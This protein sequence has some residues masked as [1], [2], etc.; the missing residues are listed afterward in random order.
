MLKFI[1]HFIAT[2]F[3]SGLSPKAPGTVGT[4][5]C[6]VLVWAFW[7]LVP[8][9]DQ[10]IAVFSPQL[11]CLLSSIVGLISIDFYYRDV[12]K[13][14]LKKFDPQEVVIDEFA[15]FL[16]TLSFLPPNSR[17]LL[18]AFVAFRFFDILKP[19]PIKIFEKQSGAWGVMLDDLAAGIY[20][21]ITLSLLLY[22]Y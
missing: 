6:A 19:W 2:G 7:N 17:S 5:C 20:G 22:L 1:T 16:L 14:N 9:A 11:L 21:G 12:N 13:E 15:G 4:L 3:F 18:L 10:I 8:N